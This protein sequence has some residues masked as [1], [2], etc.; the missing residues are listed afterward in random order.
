MKLLLT[1]S[2]LIC[3]AAL[4][5]LAASVGNAGG[6]DRSSLPISIKANQ[7]SV[8]N[9]AKM[10]V[11]TGKVMAKQGDITIYSDKM[12]IYYGD[13][14]GEV[15]KI[16]AD[17]NVRILQE[18]RIGF[19]SHAVYESKKGRITLTGNPRVTQGADSITGTTIIYLIDEDKSFVSGEGDTRVQSI[20][21]PPAKKGNAG[22]R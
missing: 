6:K 20:I 11:Y 7:L 13:E 14:K 2:I 10:A 12:S 3:L 9:V 16:E 5:L 8:D 15:E 21:H 4:P 17:G 22:S 19:A 18:N 1:I